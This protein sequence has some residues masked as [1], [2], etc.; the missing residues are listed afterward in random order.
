MKDGPVCG[1]HNAS[2]EG[3][4]QGLIKLAFAYLSSLM[5]VVCGIIIHATRLT[6]R[7]YN[8]RLD[9][10]LYQRDIQMKTCGRAHD[11]RFEDNCNDHLSITR[12][13][14]KLTLNCLRSHHRVTTHYNSQ[15][16]TRHGV[17]SPTVSR[18]RLRDL[19][20]VHL[21]R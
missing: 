9:S 11:E 16:E 7:R 20:Q 14:P 15:T 19:P 10:D 21:H 6:I 13:S 12:Y 8:T 4:L 5:S 18:R 17:D 2:A 1:I 3:S